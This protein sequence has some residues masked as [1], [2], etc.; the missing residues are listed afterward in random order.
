[1]RKSA[2]YDTAFANQ[3]VDPALRLMVHLEALDELEGIPESKLD[4][5]ALGS[6]EYHRA[7]IRIISADLSQ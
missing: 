1:M 6:L 3:P 5:I 4:W 7:C 2:S